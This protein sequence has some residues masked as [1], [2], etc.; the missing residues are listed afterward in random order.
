MLTVVVDTNIWV[1]TLIKPQ[2]QYA[3]MLRDLARRGTLYTAEEILAEAREVALR[4]H[5][6]KKYR[7]TETLVDHALTEACIFATVVTDLPVLEVVTEDPDDNLILACAV[8]AGAAYLVSYDPHLTRLHD[9]QG[10][11]ILTPQQFLPIL[12]QAPE[13]AQDR[14]GHG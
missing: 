5:I 7:L 9:Y 1:S 2:G 11:L 4:P 12:K 8:K 10:I 3:R 13:P 6:Q 14:G